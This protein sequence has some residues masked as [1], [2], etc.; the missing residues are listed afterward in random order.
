MGAT[1]SFRPLNISQNNEY[2]NSCTGLVNLLPLIL[3]YSSSHLAR[4]QGSVEN[5]LTNCVAIV[6]GSDNLDKNRNRSTPTESLVNL[7]A[8][9][10]PMVQSA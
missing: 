2:H 3:T 10:E 5:S 1:S 4:F 6:K 8:T 7:Q 9:A